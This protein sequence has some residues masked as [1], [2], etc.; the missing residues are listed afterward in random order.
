MMSRAIG[1][2]LQACIRAYQ[3][4]LSPWLGHHCRYEPTCSEYT[5]QA[6]GL[7]GPWKGVY[8]G[9]RRLLRCHPWGS[10]GHDPVPGR[11]AVDTTPARD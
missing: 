8:L 11:D 9:V 3:L 10:F 1:G 5:R 7:H 4:V 6:L 2:L